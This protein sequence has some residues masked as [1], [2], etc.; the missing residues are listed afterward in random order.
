MEA[1]S[2]ERRVS[3]EAG[4][5]I[6]SAVALAGVCVMLALGIARD[7]MKPVAGFVGLWFG[8]TSYVLLARRAMRARA[9]RLRTAPIPRDVRLTRPLWIPLAES[10]G[11]FAIGAALA[12]AASLVGYP[13][14]GV[15][16]V[17]P[18]AAV[19][20]P[21]LSAFGDVVGLTFEASGVR[22]HLRRGE[23]FLP[24]TAVLDVHTVGPSHRPS[25]NVQ[26]AGSTALHA[27]LAPDN[28][29]TQMELYVLLGLGVPSGRA[30][31][32][33]DWSAGLDCAT[34]AR[35]LREARGEPVAQV[36]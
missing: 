21:M 24:W 33:G 3:W 36:N 29:K 1:V 17:L 11:V 30:L 10:M 31:H 26:L 9:E 12:A 25:L 16:I 20:L 18:M 4:F 28:R 22:L 34:L 23:C 8:A 2:S 19:S 6:A 15:G 35:A 13:W 14:V 32:L 7:R 27:S 5:W